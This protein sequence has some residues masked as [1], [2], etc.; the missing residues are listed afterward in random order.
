MTKVTSLFPTKRV[1][2]TLYVLIKGEKM[3]RTIFVIVS[4]LHGGHRHG[5]LNP[6]TELHEYDEEGNIVKDF[7]PQLNPVQ[8][9]LWK[10]YTAQIDWIKKMSGT[11]DIVLCFNGDMTT[12]NFHDDLLTSDRMADQIVIAMSNSEPWYELPNL[13]AVR[14]I[15][16]TGVHVFGEGSS[17]LLLGLISSKSHPD[18]DCKVSDHSLLTVNGMQMDIS[19][20]GPPPGSRKWLEGNECRYY[21]RDLMMRDLLEGKTPPRM[22]FRGHYHTY[23]QEQ[24][25]ISNGTFHTSTLVLTPSFTFPNGYTRK[26]IKS[27]S[28]VTHGMVVTEIVDGQPLKIHPLV[29]TIDI[30][31]KE[32]L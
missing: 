6:A 26:V 8:E 19:H 13:K 32:I 16:G 5:L 4:D 11:D 1:I 18:V 24:L 7:H 3:K 28:R 10:I 21:L 23:A 20:H 15:K 29:K 30:R 25:T 31:T 22:V 9:Y 12:G 17:E 2:L 14:Y 27:P